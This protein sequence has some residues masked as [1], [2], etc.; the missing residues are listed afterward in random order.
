[1]NESTRASHLRRGVRLEHFTIGWNLLEAGVA[2]GA[3][4]LAGSIALV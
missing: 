1:M 4:L 3:G 2:I